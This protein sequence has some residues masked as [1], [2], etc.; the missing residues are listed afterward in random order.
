MG[1]TTAVPTKIKYPSGSLAQT[2]ADISMTADASG[3][4][5]AGFLSKGSGMQTLY[6]AKYTNGVWGLA[7]STGQTSEWGPALVWY[8]G[9]LYMFWNYGDSTIHYGSIDGTS[10]VCT[11]LGQIQDPTGSVV[12]K[13]QS[14]PAGIAWNGAMWCNH[15]GWGLSE[16]LYESKYDGEWNTE[17]PVVKQSSANSPSYAA[18]SNYQFL[19]HC[20]SDRSICQYWSVKATD[21]PGYTANQPIPDLP[22]PIGVDR[23]FGA[24]A[25]GDDYV[26]AVASY[27]TFQWSTCSINDDFQWSYQGD[28]SISSGPQGPGMCYLDGVMYLVF[29]DSAGQ[30]NMTTL[31]SIP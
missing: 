15:L 21:S 26:V 24:A 1:W 29:A 18:T 23:C 2:E 17:K 12:A 14:S 25:F 5:W 8:D 30:L 4:L 13:T 10:G 7:L 20:D 3:T 16:T 11:D 31:S 9:T 19:F 22:G 27:G 28:A 6:V